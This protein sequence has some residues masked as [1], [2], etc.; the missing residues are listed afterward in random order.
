MKRILVPIAAACL[1]TF[2]LAGC[3][4]DNGENGSDHGEGS[5]GSAQ[6]ATEASVAN[7]PGMEI[8]ING[9]EFSTPES[10]MPGQTVT[11]RNNSR[12]EHSVTSD[13]DGLFDIDVDEN[14]VDTMM[15][16]D[17]PGAYTFHCSFH[18]SMRGTLM[19]K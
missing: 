12:S 6:V 7:A 13:T 15:V 8:V 17:Q 10:V 3:G 18:P 4:T 9:Y 19:V 14:A 11:V 16:P 5:S 1:S 2:A